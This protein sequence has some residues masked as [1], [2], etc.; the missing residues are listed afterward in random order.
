MCCK[1]SKSRL[2][3]SGR[4]LSSRSFSLALRK[5]P[6]GDFGSHQEVSRWK[7]AVLVLL[8][9]TDSDGGW[10]TVSK[11]GFAQRRKA[12]EATSPRASVITA[13]HLRGSPA[14]TP[15][16]V[17]TRVRGREV[18]LRC[19]HPAFLRNHWRDQ[20]FSF[21]AF[22]SALAGRVSSTSAAT[23]FFS[24]PP[25][26]RVRGAPSLESQLGW[27]LLE[28]GGEDP[29]CVHTKPVATY[30][31]TDRRPTYYRGDCTGA[32]SA[33]TGHYTS[34]G[35]SCEINPERKREFDSLVDPRLRVRRNLFGGSSG[36]S[37]SSTPS[38]SL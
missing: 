16:K 1:G 33:K 18:E 25:L 36:G 10:S 31:L 22:Y 37:G 15:G 3:R 21:D 23:V 4:F 12:Q 27:H 19:P 28:E 7:V 20:V 29:R 8:L 30:A 6:E 14:K 34:A 32:H 9:L 11:Q 2:V 13:L 26:L 35:T 17:A 38:G 5:D 24:Y